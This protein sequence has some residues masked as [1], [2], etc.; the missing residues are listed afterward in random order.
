MAGWQPLKAL[1]AHRSSVV[2]ALS[3]VVVAEQRKAAAGQACA[4]RGREGRSPHPDPLPPRAGEGEMK[5]APLV[6]R[7]WVGMLPR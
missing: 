2:E 1:Q 6:G 4:L 7:G 3:E 5:A